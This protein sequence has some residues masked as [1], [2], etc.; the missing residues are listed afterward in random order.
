[1]SKIVVFGAGGN[2]GRLI[3]DEAARRGHA[4]TAAVRARSDVPVFAEGVNVITGDPTD[5]S[6][7]RALAKG[8]D[9]FIVAVGGADNTVWLRAARTLV[10]TLEAIPGAI[11]RI[12]HMGGGSTLLTPQ[13]GHFFDLPDFPEAFRGPAL[14][15]SEALDYYRGHPKRRVSWTYLSP[16][17]V[18][19]APGQRTG[20]YRTGLDHP[21][22][23]VTGRSRLSYEDFAIA[24]IDEVE[25]RKF[26]N[27][28]FTVGY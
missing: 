13:G 1:M 16:P 25:Q 21:V 28:R 4:V 22:E 23:D 11:P 8:E 5:S 3:T 12:L 9:V 17:P 18:Y 2:A 20:K 27:T 26:I 24:M 10:E 6:S 14:G 15:Q 19:F 7:V